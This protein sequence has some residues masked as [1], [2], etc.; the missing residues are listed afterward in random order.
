MSDRQIVYVGAVPQDTDLLLTN[1]NMM[2]GLG[3]LARAILGT[4]T[5]VDGLACTQTTVAS[6]NVLI[7]QGAIYSNVNVDGSAYG[8]L[9][10]DTTNQIV[11]QGINLSPTQLSCPA[12]GTVGQSINYLI[13]AQY[14][15]VDA[16]STILPYYNSSNPSVAYNGP[17]NSGTS[18]YTI[19]Q[20]KCILT[21]KA[22]VAATTGTQVTPTPDSGYV[23]LW[24]V[25]VANGQTTITSTNISVYPGAPFIPNNLPTIPLRTRLTANTNFYVSTTGSDANNGLTAAT[26]WLTLQNAANIIQKNYDLNGF[27]ATINLTAGTYTAGVAVN[28]PFTGATGPSSVVFLGNTGSPSSYI[29]A[30]SSGTNFAAYNGAQFTVSGIQISGA[31]AYAINADGGGS[32]INYGNVI[33][34]AA[35]AAHV[36]SGTDARIVAIGDYTITGGSQNHFFAGGSGSAIAA[37]SRNITVTGTPAFGSAFALANNCASLICQSSAISGSA[38]GNRYQASL[39]GVINTNG[40]GATFFP[41]SV[42]GSTATGGQYA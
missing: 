11:K 10:A 22:G 15:D 24:V 19:R 37:N 30:I 17:A 13:E 4:G 26:P 29:S 8:S 41:G 34:G 33:F 25:T 23:G 31:T 9:S 42:A 12:P 2:I 3:M 39:N 28:G 40:A 27:V 38:T 6:L 14:Q 16:G 36:A 32:F 7:N 18:Q 35:T 21:V 1:K 5:W 20:G